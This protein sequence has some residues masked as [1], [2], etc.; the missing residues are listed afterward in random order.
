MQ[1]IPPSDFKCMNYTGVGCTFHTE[2]M[3]TSIINTEQICVAVRNAVE[4]IPS[5]IYIQLRNK[6]NRHTPYIFTGMKFKFML[7]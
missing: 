4:N 6:Q 5:Q 7:A 3:Y 2:Q 1:Y